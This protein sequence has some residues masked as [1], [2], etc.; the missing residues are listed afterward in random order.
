M[1]RDPFFLFFW[2]K[3]FWETPGLVGKGVFPRKI[4]PPS[5]PRPLLHLFGPQS[6]S[7]APPPPGPGLRFFPPGGPLLPRAPL[8]PGPR[9]PLPPGE[10]RPRRKVPAP[11]FFAPRDPGPAPKTPG[12]PF[13]RH[14]PPVGPPF[15]G[16]WGPPPFFPPGFFPRRF[17]VWA[18]E[19]A[20][21]GPAGGGDAIRRSPSRPPGARDPGPLP[22]FFGPDSPGLLGIPRA[23]PKNKFTRTNFFP[24]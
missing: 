21:K 24:F 6:L 19:K 7:P 4:F 9:F 16:Q 20:P 18:G 13:S 17:P 14:P 11:P 23:P 10:D 2:F 22:F 12:F 8:P 3:I 1:T 15:F 5:G